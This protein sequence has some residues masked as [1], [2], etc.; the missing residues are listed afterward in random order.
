MHLDDDRIQRLLHGELGPAEAEVGAHLATCADC[1]GLLEQARAEEA[2]LFGLLTGVDHPIAT[3]D[4]H[5]LFAPTRA[6]GRWGRWAAGLLIGAALAGAAYA[7]PGSPI[8]WVLERLLGP[9]R[10]VRQP[11]H[12]TRADTASHSTRGIAVDP[13]GALVIQLGASG[14][15][16]LATISL[17]DDEVVLVR[18]VAGDA[19]F[20]SD[21]GHL[22]VRSTGAARLEILIPRAAT[23]V[24]VRA[25]GAAVLQKSAG[26][27]VT[28][29]PRDSAGR[30]SVRVPPDST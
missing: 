4:P 8:P 26:G 23:A 7:M 27:T 16:A 17:T 18:A 1:R 14:E 3:V 15:E 29:L 21:P 10:E 24:E 9:E 2:R 19:T 11:R 5:T 25:D 13:D 22:T 12:A 30:Y 20:T 6:E 28:T